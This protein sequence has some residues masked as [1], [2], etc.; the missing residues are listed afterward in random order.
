MDGLSQTHGLNKGE[1]REERRRE[2]SMEKKMTEH[3]FNKLV[4]AGYMIRPANL[5]DIE[6]SVEMFNLCSKAMI[7]AP[8]FTVERF[9]KEWQTPNFDLQH[10]T[11]LV[12]APTGQIVGCIEVWD[13]SEPPVHPWIWGH[14]HPAWE[15]KSIGTAMMGWAL[16]RAREAI[17]RAGTANT[18]TPAKELLRNMGMDVIRYEW[19]MLIDL[20]EEPPAPLW[21]EGISVRNI[22]HPDDTEAA[23]R[24]EDEAFQDHWGY[25][26]TPFEDGFKQWEYYVFEIRRPDPA[27]WFLAMDEDEIAGM[28]TCRSESDDDPDKGWVSVLGVRR[29]WRRRGLGLALLRQVIAEFYRRGKPR[30][31]LGV[32]SNNISGATKLYE[33]AGM[34]V[35]REYVAYESELRTGEELQ[36]E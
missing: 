29:P 36:K 7:G 2:I 18:Y 1:H 4:S 8:E 21:P 31:G 3:T 32:D 27:L 17:P 14:V 23:Y 15:G 13:V 34:H 5:E 33:K 6:G 22:Q 35:Q 16:E 26:E 25:V 9:A 24:A 19:D 30:V 11:R 20:N 28:V 12:I 10:D